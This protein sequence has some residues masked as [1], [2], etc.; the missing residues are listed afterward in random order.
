MAHNVKGDVANG[1]LTL[2]I[3]LSDKAKAAAPMS[4]SEK[5]KVLATTGGFTSFGGNAKVSLN[6]TIDK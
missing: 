5:S 6:V 4:K 3:D 2:V 1:I